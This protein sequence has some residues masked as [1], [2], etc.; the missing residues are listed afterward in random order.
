MDIAALFKKMGSELEICMGIATFIASALKGVAW[1]KVAGLAMEYGP[2]LY[3]MACGRL[4]K[5][6]DLPPEPTEEENELRQRI[7]RLEKLLVEQEEVIRGQV[8]RNEQLQD[9][10]LKLEGQ[11]NR[12]RIVSAILAVI[13]IG[14]AV[15]LIRQG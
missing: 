12:F 11:M 5:E 2:E 8:A 3:R 15:M 10:C 9:A 13:A 7:D 6:D 4:R 14:F 1:G